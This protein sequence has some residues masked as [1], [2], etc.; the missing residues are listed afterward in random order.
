MY[1]IIYYKESSISIN[2]FD[3]LVIDEKILLD[4]I[5]ETNSGG[6]I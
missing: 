3:T 2:T 4:I 1:S 6:E 5:K